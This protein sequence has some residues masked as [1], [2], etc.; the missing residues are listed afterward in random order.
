MKTKLYTV[1]KY[2]NGKEMGID[3]IGN[4]FEYDQSPV[5]S[6]ETACKIA[7]AYCGNITDAFR[8]PDDNM[9]NDQDIREDYLSWIKAIKQ[10]SKYMDQSGGNT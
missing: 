6:Y 7:R 3:I 1:V 10:S 9:D 8:E 5:Y 2:S 4:L